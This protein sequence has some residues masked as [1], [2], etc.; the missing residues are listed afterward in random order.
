L[1]E[2]AFAGPNDPDER[3]RMVVNPIVAVLI[4]ASWARN[5]YCRL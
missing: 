1:A 3:I 4:K 2:S 5:D